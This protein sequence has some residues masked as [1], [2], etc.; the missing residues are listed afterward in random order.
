MAKDVVDRFLHA[1][2]DDDIDTMRPLVR[3]DII[4]WVPASAA[5]RFNLARPL[6]GWDK[7]PWLGGGGWKAFEP[8]SSAL[9]IHH[10]VAEGNLVSAHYQ[11]TATLLDGQPYDAEYNLLIRLAGVEIAE[12]WEVADTATAF[13]TS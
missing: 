4:W 12:V 3:S 13:R 8:G 10:M 7:I 11:R 2:V 5:A 6:K 1:L 9:T